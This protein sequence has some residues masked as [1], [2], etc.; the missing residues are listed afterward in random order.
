MLVTARSWEAAP[1]LEGELFNECM[2]AALP[3]R[4]IVHISRKA[5]PHRPYSYGIVTYAPDLRTRG[6]I[7]TLAGIDTPTCEGSLVFANGA[8]YFANPSSQLQRWNMT[9]HKS[10]D[11][12]DSEDKHV[13]NSSRETGPDTRCCAG[14]PTA[15]VIWPASAGIAGY[16]GIT[17]TGDGLA[18]IFEGGPKTT[19]HWEDTWVKVTV[20]PYF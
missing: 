7:R 10:T 14:W 4:S 9:I 6:P 12:G 13:Q 8:L 11:G 1:P 3:N 19:G 18:L 2:I 16:S 5:L 17:D 15:R 20:V